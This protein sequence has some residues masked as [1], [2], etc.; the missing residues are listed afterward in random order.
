MDEGVDWLSEFARL[1][2]EIADHEENKAPISTRIEW[3]RSIATLQ[4]AKIAALQ[5]EA[6]GRKGEVEKIWNYAAPRAF[7]RPFL[8]VD[9]YE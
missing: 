1:V 8:K 7:K 9:Q 5:L 4:R 2:L 3:T 6:E